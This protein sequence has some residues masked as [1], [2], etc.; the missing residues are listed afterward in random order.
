MQHEVSNTSDQWSNICLFA[1]EGQQNKHQKCKF[2]V[3]YNLIL[4]LP[5]YHDDDD[6]ATEDAEDDDA[7]KA[8]DD[9][10]EQKPTTKFFPRIF[11][12]LSVR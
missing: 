4:F 6:D 9:N 2:F 12:Q 8:D 11:V 5:N 3:T 1:D 7:V 10:D